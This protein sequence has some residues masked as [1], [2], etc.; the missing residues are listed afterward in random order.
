MLVLNHYVEAM[1]VFEE[2]IDF[3]DGGVI[4][5]L[6]FPDLLLKQ[7]PL[8]TPYLILIHYIDCSNEGR[9]FVDYFPELIE[10]VLLQAGG[11]DFILLL[12]SALNLFDEVHLLEL[13][14]ILLMN[15]FHCTLVS[16]ARSRFIAHLFFLL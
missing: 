11:K 8:V 4:D 1:V 12:N 2:L 14:L 10:L 13:N 16:L 3:R 7:F 9:L 15:D 5:L 6:Q